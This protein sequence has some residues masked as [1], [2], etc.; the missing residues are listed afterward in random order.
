MTTLR[1][2]HYQGLG[3]LS[4][5]RKSKSWNGVAIFLPLGAPIWKH[6]EKSCDPLS[7]VMSRGAGGMEN[8]MLRLRASPMYNARNQSWNQKKVEREL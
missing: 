6:Q 4:R 8:V 1:G 3:C 2:S 7:S 5:F